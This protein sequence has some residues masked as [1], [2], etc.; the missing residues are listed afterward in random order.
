MAL[1]WFKVDTGIASNARVG[2]VGAH[3]ALVFLAAL[4]QHARH[5]A[6]GRIPAAHMTPRALKIEAAALMVE[7]TEKKIGHAID[8]CVT[9]GLF[10]RD[11]GSAAVVLAGFDE[12]FRVKCVRC[13]GPNDS[14][15]FSSCSRCRQRKQEERAAPGQRPGSDTA[16]ARAAVDRT[17]LDRTGQEPNPQTRAREAPEPSIGPP[18][19]SGGP[20]ASGPAGSSGGSPEPALASVLF[21]ETSWRANATHRIAEVS[22]LSRRLA[23]EGITVDELRRIWVWAQRNGKAPAAY[24]N[25]LVASEATW[26]S[27]LR[28]SAECAV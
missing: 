28:Q 3:G 17:R 6:E 27:A 8:L 10:A 16:S 26:R 15:R 25:S 14:P 4:A 2:A 23:G 24:F 1:S 20:S 9:E 22:K 5:G 19:G 7:L 18:E 11:E 12:R 13:H 21:D